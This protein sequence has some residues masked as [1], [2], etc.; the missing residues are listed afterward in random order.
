LKELKLS[1]RELEKRMMDL[2]ADL[3]MVKDRSNVYTELRRMV[4]ATGLIVTFGVA[5]LA[6]LA[7]I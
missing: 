4:F 6:G 2:K 5:T 1:S 7:N 3:D